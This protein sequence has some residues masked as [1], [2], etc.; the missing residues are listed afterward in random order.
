MSDP[1]V[2]QLYSVDY[3]QMLQT[4]CREKDAEIE[5]LTMLNTAAKGIIHASGVENERLDNEFHALKA[6]TRRMVEAGTRL[7]D[8]QV[9]GNPSDDGPYLN[10]FADLQAA[11]ADPVLVGIR[12][13]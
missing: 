12:R 3:V 13:E 6:A 1:N 11:L 2:M 7:V 4:V 8:A 9:N 5:R 10:A